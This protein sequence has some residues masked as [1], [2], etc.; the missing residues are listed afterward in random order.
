[1]AEESKNGAL[2]VSAS[3]DT[4]GMSEAA[5][6][7]IA[8]IN[9]L[10]K[11][12][13]NLS[14]VIKHSEKNLKQMGITSTVS[15]AELKQ[16]FQTAVDAIKKYESETEHTAQSTKQMEDAV[17]KFGSNLDSVR[18]AITSAYENI[19]KLTE[20][21]K[22]LREQFEKADPGTKAYGELNK[23]LQINNTALTHCRDTANQLTGVYN[24][25]AANI[26]ALSAASTAW[27]SLSTTSIVTNTAARAASA[28]TTLAQ[29]DADGKWKE[30]IKGL[31]DTEN[32]SIATSKD[33]ISTYEEFISVLERMVE[34]FHKLRDAGDFLGADKTLANINQL[35]YQNENGEYVKPDLSKYDL[36][37]TPS[38]STQSTEV[39]D[40]AAKYAE[41]LRRVQQEL[42]A[43]ADKYPQIVE[44]NNEVASG[45]F[46]FDK[47]EALKAKFGDVVDKYD[48][49]IKKED[50]LKSKLAETGTT[51]NL[52][53]VEQQVNNV[54]NATEEATKKTISFKDAWN[55]FKGSISS[56]KSSI[57]STFS[58]FTEGWRNVKTLHDELRSQSARLKE[59][60]SEYDKL[61]ESKSFEKQKD[62][63]KELA[64]EIQH[65]KTKIAEAKQQYNEA[66]KGSTTGFIE[67]LNLSMKDFVTWNGKFSNNLALLKTSLGNMVTPLTGV[68]GGFGAVAKAMWAMAMTPLGAVITIIV[69]GLQAMW[70]WLNKSA[71]GQRVLTELSAYLG[72]IL[73]S[74]I[75]V[76][77]ALGK[78]LF[79]CFTK[80]DGALHD[81]GINF[82]N[83]F[84]SAVKA[85]VDLIGG[86]GKTIKGVFTMDWDTF[87]DGL[88]QI[89][90]GL[91]NAGTTFINSV[92]TAISGIKGAYGVLTGYDANLNSKMSELFSGQ[93]LAKAEQARQL[94]LS[95][96]D[97][98]QK[99]AK[100]KQ[101]EAAVDEQ[102]A[103]SREKIYTLTGKEKL[104][105]IENLKQLQADKYKPRIAALQ[106][107]A[108]NQLKIN[109]LHE[110]SLQDIAKERELR[111]Q[112]L[113]LQAQQAA[114]TRFATRMEQTTL[115]QIANEGKK[116]ARQQE[117]I[118]QAQ[119]KYDEVVHD[120]AQAAAQA[121]VK[122]EQQLA[123]ARIAAMK[124]GAEKVRAEKQRQNEKDL[125]QIRMAQQKAV[126][127]ERDRQ[128]K[129]YDAQ[130]AII[131]ARGGS[132]KNWDDSMLDQKAIDKINSQYETLI[133]LTAQK[134]NNN[135]WANIGLSDE[136]KSYEQQREELIKKWDEVLKV[137]EEEI[138]KENDPAKRD[139]LQKALI[140]AQENKAK[141]LLDLDFNKLKENPDYIRAY[142]NLEKTS[143]DTLKKLVAQFEAVKKSAASSLNPKDLKE[144]TDAINR[145][146]DELAKRNPFKALADSF[147]ELKD[148]QRDLDFANNILARVN[149]G[150]KVWLGKIRFVDGKLQKVYETKESAQARQANAQQNYDNALDKNAKAATQSIDMIADAM[151]QLGDVIG[152]VAGQ[153]MSSMSSLMGSISSKYSVLQGGGTQGWFAA[154]QIGLSAITTGV[155][156][157]DSMETKNEAARKKQAEINNL[158]DS[159]YAYR[160][161]VREAQQAEKKWFASTNI[162][163]LRDD[164]K[165]QVDAIDKYNAKLNE[166]QVAYEDAGSGLSKTWGVISGGVIGG[167]LGALK[168]FLGGNVIGAAV[169]AV[170]GTVVGIG[171]QAA[172]NALASE[173]NKVRAQDNLR[174]QT[175]HRTFFRGEKTQDLQGWIND[176]MRDKAFELGITDMELFDK[177]NK[178]NVEL[179]RAVLDSGATLVGDSKET[180][181][182]LITYQEQINEFEKNLEEYVSDLY[183]PL[184]DDMNKALWDWYENGK[185]A[186][187]AFYDYAADTF[188]NI[189][190]EMTKEMINEQVFSGLKD[191]LK[192]ITRDYLAKKMSDEQ[193]AQAVADAMQEAA[194]TYENILPQLQNMVTALDNSADSIG[195]NMDSS[196]GEAQG[197]VNA[198]MSI[199][200]D[201]ANE[202]V[203]CATAMQITA[204]GI[205]INSNLIVASQQIIQQDVS[206]MRTDV[207]AMAIDVAEIKDAQ[208]IANNY[209]S[210]IATNT[211]QLYEMNDKLDS[212]KVQL[213]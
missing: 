65:V 161:A 82:V 53:P 116:D 202:L 104:K 171:A 133:Q 106:T 201:T 6:Q 110:S 212:I 26:G 71:E 187:D 139:Y 13:D 89:G 84:K 42:Q 76:V 8:D 85:V 18:S 41:E 131:K 57:S 48:E 32:D 51:T 197:T 186:M 211:A 185:D 176:N 183:S 163:R 112:V 203:G 179:A 151:K 47:Y 125:E 162:G 50:E 54:S 86:L 93:S 193:Y 174:V 60:Q 63:A 33:R 209:L 114:A 88:K 192:D 73:N 111:T 45:S 113:S 95:N 83:T 194:T 15:S 77:I 75:D 87:T 3:L 62:K 24:D 98:E 152:G 7:A 121:Q 196:S 168:G 146:N 144:Y 23:Q 180:L 80:S 141:G 46:D 55:S 207:G 172:A 156:I 117:Q 91:K 160:D 189:G 118:T 137:L 28:S 148:A 135:W 96:L 153:I 103:A 142:E 170:A 158:I 58:S 184:L 206:A 213:S 182:E 92:K 107:M 123:D 10:E 169:G 140:K 21:Q 167:V 11:T 205:L 66:S 198:A 127:D 145:M 204:E 94:A 190:K 165:D 16:S 195:I 136:L 200:E 44:F 37:R 128:K 155:S 2:G 154:A 22:N 143:T 149:A 40:V 120:N 175:Q 181:Q 72:S 39:L 4:Q 147:K 69:G 130:Q 52:A 35:T 36:S 157:M 70:A 138:A 173:G 9:S 79:D 122:L 25:V 178:L 43:I 208:Q 97:T 108:D 27:E 19:D 101:Q 102:I 61:A 17:A 188:K 34:Q 199:T 20:K 74:V 78:Y 126:Q 29:I 90:D 109:E 150:E 56:A 68:A 210:Q 115:K 177:N 31:T 99:I 191:K 67:R 129:E 119:G 132:M 105:E 49:L 5:K 38:G 59:L 30:S 159:V 100:L 124:E 81:F 1:M 64:N 134:N 166:P 14:K 12:V 164:L